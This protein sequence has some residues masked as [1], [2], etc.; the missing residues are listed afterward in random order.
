MASQ[1][2]PLKITLKIL[3]YAPKMS[4]ETYC[5][6]ADV[7]V[8]GKLVAHASN[9]GHGGNTNVQPYTNAN[10]DGGKRN[11]KAWE[12]LVAHCNALPD[13]VHAEYLIE[14]KPMTTKQNV[15]SVVDDLMDNYVR[16]VYIPKVENAKYRR[17]CKTK[18]IYRLKS[19][20][21]ADYEIKQ[22]Y[23]PGLKTHL[24]ARFKDDL[25]EIINERL[26]VESA[27][28]SSPSKKDAKSSKTAK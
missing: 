11:H 17:K 2:L 28:L 27:V 12:E 26:R 19:D 9:A 3:A 10:T 8:D 6:K 22:L 20:P 14:G 7:Y 15:E 1:K 24:E 21:G 23:S 4:E 18:T 5:F 25:E 13:Q 16:Q